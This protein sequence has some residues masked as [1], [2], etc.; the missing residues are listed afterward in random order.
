MLYNKLKST[1]NRSNGN[2]VWSLLTTVTPGQ[3]G[4]AL[5]TSSKCIR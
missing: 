3:T 4:P 2:G 1:T 5:G